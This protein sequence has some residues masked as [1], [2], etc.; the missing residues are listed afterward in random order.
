MKQFFSTNHQKTSRQIHWL[1]LG[2]FEG[3]KKLE[4]EWA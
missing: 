4:Q 2:W 3:G 1:K